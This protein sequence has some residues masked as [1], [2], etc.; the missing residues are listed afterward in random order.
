M[1]VFGSRRSIISLLALTVG[2][3]SPAVWAQ[4]A[5]DNV[6]RL[7]FSQRLN[8][9]VLAVGGEAGW[10]KEQVIIQVITDSK[11]LFEQPDFAALM[12]NLG[13]RALA[14]KCPAAKRL[15][16]SGVE[17]ASGAVVW[18][19]QAE[20]DEWKP[21]A[22]KQTAETK[23]DIQSPAPAVASKPPVEDT[24]PLP[25]AGSPL[26][27]EWTADARCSTSGEPDKL[28][29]SVYEV[30]GST[31]K[32]VWEHLSPRGGIDRHYVTGLYDDLSNQIG[33]SS[34]NNG[35]IRLSGTYNVNITGAFD[36]K[37]PSVNLNFCYSKAPFALSRAS[38]V[39]T[40]A[41]RVLRDAMIKTKWLEEEK[42]RVKEWRIVG[43]SPEGRLRFPGCNEL[44][45]WAALFSTEQRV[46]L[47][48]GDNN[49]MLRH[50]DDATT[51][52]VFGS[53]AYYWLSTENINELTRHAA[54]VCGSQVYHSSSPQMRQLRN[55]VQDHTSA[56]QMNERR[57]YDAALDS[58]AP[59][60]ASRGDKIADAIANLNRFAT[61]ELVERNLHEFQI[62]SGRIGA[63]EKAAVLRNVARYKIKLA[64]RSR[65]TTLKE[66]AAA[67][68]TADGRSAIG[69]IEQ[70]AVSLFGADAA[71]PI[72]AAAA[73]RRAEIAKTIVA[74][75]VADIAVA[76][77]TLDGWDRIGKTE[78]ETVRLLSAEN[79]GPV[80]AAASA[81]RTE[82]AKT[83]VAEAIA[84]ITAAKRD[85]DGVTDID[86]KLSALR[87]KLQG[88]NGKPDAGVAAPLAELSRA[89][90]KFLSE[91]RD[92]VV[93]S[94]QQ[95]L[96]T[97]PATL[98]GLQS[99]DSRLKDLERALGKD[100]GPLFPAYQKAV[101]AKKD[102]IGAALLP[103]LKAELNTLPTEWASVD[104]ARKLA[105]ERAAPF[106]G[107]SIQASY[108][109]AGAD[110]GQAVMSA[111]AD[112]AIL[113]I[114]SIEET[115]MKGAQ[116]AVREAQR[117]AASFAGKEGGKP[118]AD[119]IVEAGRKRAG[120]ITD[121]YLP[122]FR[123]EIKSARHSRYTAVQL[124]TA[125]IYLGEGVSEVPAFSKLRDT[126]QEAAVA[127]YAG[128]CDKT[129]ANSNISSSDAKTPILLGADIAPLRQFICELNDGGI[130][131]TK[132][133]TPGLVASITGGEKHYVL[134]LFGD[135]N[136]LQFAA[137]R[138]GGMR[139]F[140]AKDFASLEDVFNFGVDRNAESQ[141][142]GNA[143]ESPAKI[144][145]KEMEIRENQTALVGFQ[146][147][148]DGKTE[149][150]SLKEW[151]EISQALT[152]YGK[153]GVNQN[154]LCAAWKKDGH[155]NLPPYQAGLALLSCAAKK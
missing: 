114:K 147:G 6:E 7:G 69:K 34:P 19:G 145:F 28:T 97:T 111:L 101:A 39:P 127:M 21:T 45:D 36:P 117:A 106:A 81:R 137:L 122:E 134:R 143:T 67:P 27:G 91:A 9:E 83:A 133:E 74:A 132:F 118:V 135:E 75:A 152:S 130:R 138:S 48:P 11:T 105:A 113:D 88:P 82:I 63:E 13:S 129:M 29:L 131:V 151:R 128:L 94:A 12:K 17:K 72:A 23:T 66:I 141:A 30:S 42:N 89:E 98:D 14:T 57:T 37:K 4:T 76:P 100:P 102:E 119:R 140:A 55:V 46:R 22:V 5:G 49:G 2:S 96:T 20:P 77:L 80:A 86:L 58:I 16:I 120:E 144:V 110:R 38:A 126:A 10:C 61:L 107:L 18:V 121:A 148:D 65:D 154:A 136:R 90:A 71:A 155:K 59:H 43:K 79:A 26:G 35:V 51:Q 123:A 52:R 15:A 40:T 50:F 103:E 73:A 124:A 64:E 85:F 99:V 139:R 3:L 70:E 1:T 84:D 56:Y 115:G 24:P 32:A 112:Q 60:L 149:A 62:N 33:F 104:E 41:H 53:P 25:V 68:A 93:K 78:R 109:K 87:G 142:Q 54:G 47:F 95:A 150:M 92:E 146:Y 8:A 31:F 153:D 44:A 125:S 116:N 108:Q